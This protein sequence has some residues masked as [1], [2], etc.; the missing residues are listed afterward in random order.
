MTSKSRA[1]GCLCGRI[2][3]E[4]IGEA[5]AAACCYCTDCQ[6]RTG[7]DRYL[8][9]WLKEGAFR[10]SQGE[11]KTYARGSDSG[12]GR[13]HHFCGDCGIHLYILAEPKNIVSLSVLSLDEPLGFDPALA[14]FTASASPWTRLPAD[15]PCH[16]RMPSRRS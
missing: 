9:L 11:P 2:R 10:L 15:I 13:V 5:M 14:I 6:R 8:S 3:Y 12:H 7:S 4:V 16:E 1:G